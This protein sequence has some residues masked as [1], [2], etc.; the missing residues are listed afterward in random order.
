EEH[1]RHSQPGL[2]P[3]NGAR[4]RRASFSGGWESA[5][6]R[7]PLARALAFGGWGLGAGEERTAK[8]ERRMEIEVKGGRSARVRLRPSPSAVLPASPQSPAPSPSSLSPFIR[9]C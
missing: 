1:L 8:G 9:A 5:R 7:G 3:L 4:L 2:H 6:Q